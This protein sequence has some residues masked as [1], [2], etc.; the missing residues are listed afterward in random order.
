MLRIFGLNGV[1]FAAGVSEA[2]SLM[3]NIIAYIL[4]NKHYETDGVKKSVESD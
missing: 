1:W 4:H 3:I 2:L